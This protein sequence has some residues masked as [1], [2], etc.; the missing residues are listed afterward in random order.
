[1]GLWE[2]LPVSSRRNGEQVLWE[3]AAAVSTAAVVDQT[4]HTIDTAGVDLG[5]L[6][7]TTEQVIVGHRKKPLLRKE[8]LEVWERLNADDIESI[9]D[10]PRGKAF[11]VSGFRPANLIICA[12]ARDLD[13]LTDAVNA[14]W[15]AN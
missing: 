3:G 13:G 4:V 2:Q 9:Q 1:M 5:F 7:V 15:M 6:I 12:P 11:I 14:F 8:Q 10:D